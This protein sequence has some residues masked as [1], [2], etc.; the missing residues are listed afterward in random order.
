MRNLI[1]LMLVTIIMFLMMK[2]IIVLLSKIVD[3]IFKISK[4]YKGFDLLVSITILLVFV[5]TWIVAMEHMLQKYDIT[6]LEFFGAFCFIGV[7]VVI[8][9][10]FSWDLEHFF[11][12]IHIASKMEQRY[13]KMV[14]YMLILVFSLVQGYYQT[15]YVMEQ[16]HEIPL[17]FSVANYSSVVIAIALDRVLNQ[18]V[19]ERVERQK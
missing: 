16:V 7:F 4:E 5:Y 11:V 10:Y 8:W 19:M 15:V 13:K 17:L 14:L 18:V 12:R 2:L 6:N 1:I 3:K 9:C